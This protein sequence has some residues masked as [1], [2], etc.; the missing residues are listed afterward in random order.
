MMM[1][2]DVPPQTFD[3]TLTGGVYGSDVSERLSCS[4]VHTIGPFILTYRF[5]AP[6][7]E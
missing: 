3:E 7:H 6:T 1:E 5:T 4:I 2:P